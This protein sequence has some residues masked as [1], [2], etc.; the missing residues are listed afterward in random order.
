MKKNLP[1]NIC[2]IPAVSFVCKINLSFFKSWFWILPF[3]AKWKYFSTDDPLDMD[4]LYGESMISSI[5]E[6]G[7]LKWGMARKAPIGKGQNN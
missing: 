1:F 6:S 2:S 4:S 5:P 3:S 7:G